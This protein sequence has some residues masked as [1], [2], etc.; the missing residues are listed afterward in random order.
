MEAEA[1]PVAGCTRLRWLSTPDELL[2]LAQRFARAP[3]AVPAQARERLHR[4]LV[5]DPSAWVVAA[6]RAELWRAEAAVRIAREAYDGAR[7]PGDRELRAL[8]TEAGAPGLPRTGV[9]AL[10]GLDGSGKSTQ[11]HALAATLSKLGHDTSV[12]WTRLSFD[13]SLDVVAAPVKALIAARR[14][15]TA[16]PESEP[17]AVAEP[18]QAS[19]DLR[20]RSAVVNKVW[21]GVVATA[22]GTSQ[23]RTTLAQLR[24]GRIVVRDRYVLDSVVQLHSVYGG[25]DDV[26]RQAAIVERLS[27]PPLAAFYLEVPPDE[28]HRRK[29]EEYSV[30]ELSAHAALYQRE[31]RRLGVEV[32]DAARDRADIAAELARAVWRL[33]S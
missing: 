33:V 27:P 25:R 24:A 1:A 5:A 13:A 21:T 30:E 7:L 16:L 4:V 15:L 17:G 18:D 8:C 12:E 3:G 10:S 28:A 14:R 32:V 20:D 22:N 23:R 2:L 26:S 11:S 9:V 19:R 31:A 29:P 6:G